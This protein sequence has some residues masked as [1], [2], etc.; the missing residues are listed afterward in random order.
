MTLNLLPFLTLYFGRKAEG[1]Q[2]PEPRQGVTLEGAGAT[3]K[4]GEEGKLSAGCWLCSPSGEGEELGSNSREGVGQGRSP[5]GD[6]PW[7]LPPVGNVNRSVSA[8]LKRCPL[9]RG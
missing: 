8:R 2:G 6:K 7:S 4:R 9:W 1:W 5:D 3:P